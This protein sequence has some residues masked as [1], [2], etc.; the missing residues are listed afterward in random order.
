MFKRA[1]VVMLPTNE[2]ST[3]IVKILKNIIS[4][5]TSKNIPVAT[6]QHL[7]ITSNDEIKDG[8][9][10]IHTVDNNFIFRITNSYIKNNPNYK[11]YCEKIIA[12]TDKLPIES[13]QGHFEGKYCTNY[14][15]QPSQ[16][17]IEKYVEEY[18][19]GNIITDVMVKYERK[20]NS[21]LGYKEYCYLTQDNTALNT[22]G[23]FVKGNKY[24]FDNYE[25]EEYLKVN[26]K[27]NTITIKKVKDSW[28]REEVEEL[29]Y[30]AMKDR[31]YTTI[32]EWRKWIEENL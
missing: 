31:C 6:Y 19:K 17:F 2:K 20:T 28:N 23:N 10:C 3:N 1:K 12:T 11:D 18:N 14:L 15:P 30:S 24:D 5:T 32:A 26:P 8:D 4:Y 29:I 27:D 16:A 13:Y 25:I 21:S 7:Y 9:W 22:I